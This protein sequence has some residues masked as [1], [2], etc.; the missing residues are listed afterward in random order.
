[1]SYINFKGDI[2]SDNFELSKISVTDDKNN[3]VEL[4]ILSHTKVA[5]IEYLLVTDKPDEDQ[6]DVFILKEACSGDE[7]V[8]YDVVEDNKELEIV[9]KVFSELLDDVDFEIEN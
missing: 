4:Y 2:M 7:D 5:G 3:E 6:A 9:T 1:M 8:R